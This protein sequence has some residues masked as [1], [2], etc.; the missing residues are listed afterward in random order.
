MADMTVAKYSRT[1]ITLYGSRSWQKDRR[2][3]KT[4]HWDLEGTFYIIA[5]KMVRKV[6]FETY[7]LRI[8]KVKGQ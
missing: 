2:I 5:D 6:V 3:Y 8:L 7:S 1:F 4:R